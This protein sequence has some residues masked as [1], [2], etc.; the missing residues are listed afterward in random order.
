[1]Q[2]TRIHTFA[3]I[4]NIK[5][6]SN[7]QFVRSAINEVGERKRQYPKSAIINSYNQCINL[8]ASRCYQK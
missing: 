2:I 7:Q 1:M 3:V 8:E 6:S 4:S 5:K